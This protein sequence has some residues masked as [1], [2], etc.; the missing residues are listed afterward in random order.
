V[1]RR[2]DAES[3][4][5]R[6]RLAWQTPRERKRLELVTFLL[7]SLAAFGHIVE[8]Y[9]TGDPIVRWDVSFASWLHEH[10]NPALVTAFKLITI[11][12]NAAFLA[13]VVVAVGVVLL[14]RRARNDA[15]LL[16]AVALGIEILNAGLKLAFHRPRPELSFIH[17]DT[18]SFPS[19]HAAGATAIYGVL[20]FLAA[21]HASVV[22]RVALVAAAVVLIALVDFSRLY[23]GAHYLSDVLAGSA[24]GASWLALCLLVQHELRR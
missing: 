9:L 18:Y 4:T 12:G 14:R 2:V 5:Q 24:L 22:R 20:V 1:R 21:R 15:V 8:D 16:A 13:L 19:G 7:V 11:A 23:L 6:A 3:F 17:L 10:S